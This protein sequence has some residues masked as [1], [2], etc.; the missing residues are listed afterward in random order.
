MLRGTGPLQVPSGLRPAARLRVPLV[1]R[2]SVVGALVGACCLL[3][4]SSALAGRSA[5]AFSSAGTPDTLS[6]FAGTGSY[7]AATPGPA[8]SS[9]LGGPQDVAV[10]SSGN[11]FIAD[12]D[13]NLVE[14][15]TPSGT[16]SIVAGNGTYGSPTP[17]PGTSSD[18]DGPNGVA[19]DAAGDVYIADG[20]NNE[21]EMVTPAGT[22]SIVAGTGTAGVP[23][24]GAATSSELNNPYMVAIDPSGNLFIADEYNN[25]IE[26]VTPGGALSIFAGTGNQ[27]PAVAGPATSSG[28]GDVRGL[29]T[30]AAG[31]VYIADDYNAEVEEVTPA[32]TLSIIAG[33]G[34]Y[35]TETPGPALSSMLANPGGMAIDSAGDLLLADQGNNVVEEI[36]P[37]GTLSVIAGTG[38]PQG[39]APIAG[40]PLSSGL[41]APTGVA[42]DPAGDAYYIADYGNSVVEKVAP[43]APA[44]T[45]PP[46]ISGTP[47]VGETLTASTGSWSSD[48]TGYSYQWED[49]DSTGANCTLISGATSSTYAL[50]GT[51]LGQTVEVVVTASNGGGSGSATAT[52]TA[53][54]QAPTTSTTTTTTT[55]TTPTTTPTT[56]TV[57]TT[58][59]PAPVAVAVPVSVGAVPS[60]GIAVT[61]K[62]L[63]MLSLV[64]PATP[65]GCDVSGVLVIDL[66]ASLLEHAAIVAEQADSAATG[67]GT[68]LASFSGQHIAGGHSALIAVKLNASVLRQLQTLRIRRVKVTLTLSNHLT[69]GPA[70]STTDDLYLQIP[71]LSAGACPVPT[72]HITATTI[73]PVTLGATRSRERHVLSGYT[74]RNYHTDNF[75]LYDGS[76]IRV[77]Y[78]SPKLLG[79][80][81]TTA[82]PTAHPT[83]T[84][85]VILALTAN[86]YYRLDGIGPGSAF[87]AAK[88]KLKL[89]DGIRIGV[90]TWYVLVGRR[91][92]WVLK[93][94]NAK[95]QEIGTANKTLTATTAQQRA[96]LRRF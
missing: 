25:E 54:V 6:I 53:V 78:A 8:T 22:L 18:L 34:S 96:L 64:C 47:T 49:C 74:A 57:T 61:N 15:V 30:D 17:G 95:I 94:R 84:G 32:G 65:T 36:T 7:G 60:A 42:L 14:E 56:T 11:V 38:G 87:R 45:T 10:D 92:S 44:A 50:T 90:N 70:T 68:V 35:G 81:A 79:A 72:G 58:P 41:H 52:A 43:P 76:G 77:G 91:T 82:R 69:G 55:T 80:A 75:C 51:D 83:A 2:S 23:T 48:P 67:T 85:R 1:G 16:L 62:G 4:A 29:A 93:V 39:A 59:T 27:S 89:K 88:T 86:P 5:P 37:S 40:P 12:Y 66:P 31:D 71:P 73:G 26:K 46:S 9:P 24:P 33:D 21:V 13:G 3:G 20:G 63:A 28:M 19:V